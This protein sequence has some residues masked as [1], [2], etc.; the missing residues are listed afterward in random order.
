MIEVGDVLRAADENDP[1]DGSLVKIIS[2]T[3][4]GCHPDCDCNR[5]MTIEVLTG[6]KA[7]EVSNNW[8]AESVIPLSPLEKLAQ[9]ADDL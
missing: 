4:E 3:N 8:G 6:P 1:Y 5:N 7:G 9:Q 2:L